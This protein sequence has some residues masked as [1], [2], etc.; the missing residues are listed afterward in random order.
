M[1]LNHAEDLYTLF[2]LFEED[3][4]I[5]GNSILT[6]DENI[7]TLQALKN[8]FSCYIDNFKTGSESFDEK[9][10]EQF[11]DADIGTR[12]VFAHAEWLWAFS[13]DDKTQWRKKEFTKRTTGITDEA[14][15][16]DVYPKGFG[17]AGQWHNQNKYWEI[18]FNLL[19]ILFLKEKIDKKE[20]ISVG[21]IS[22]WIEKICLYQKYEQV[23][24]DY[25]LPESFTNELPTQKLAACN[26]LT[27]IA[28]PE[29]YERIASDTHKWQ[30]LSSFSGLLSKE[31]IEGEKNVDEKIEI[32]RERLSNL[33]GESEFDFYEDEFK[34]VWNY[35]LAQEGFSE[36]QGLQYKKAIILFGPPGTSKTYT[37]KRLGHALIATAYLSNP[38]NVETY[39]NGKVDFTA[40]RI[41]H[42]QLHSNY[43]YEDFVAGIQL[44]NHSTKVVKGKLFEI[45]EAAEKDKSNNMP[46]VLILDE[47]NRI[48]LSRLFGEVFSALENRE[49]P[50][51][52][53]IGQ[54]SLIIPE[55]LYV[56]GTMNEIDFSLERIDFALRRRFLWFFYGF[57][58]NTL[59]EIIWNKNQK[60]NTRLK[61]E[62]VE[63]F[64]NNAKS[65]NRAVVDLPELGEQYQVGHTFFAEVVNIFHSYKELN[66]YSN[67]LKNQLFRPDGAA[68]IL[69]D[70]SIGPIIGAFLGNM[71]KQSKDD[72]IEEL[73]EVFLR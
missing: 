32:I 1:K 37:A 27:Y 28:F 60:L 53:G 4:L 16:K 55:N 46:H 47:I 21:Q 11:K 62:E 57:E 66:G 50:I 67:R 19:L 59:S 41:H 34:Q 65:L 33:S 9:V 63:R 7:L 48:D 54:L 73:K 43:N 30:I 26:I 10:A 2:N 18:K 71:D 56:I 64:V 39:F 49:E 5:K 25:P 70:V 61:P 72:K 31:E 36:V 68:N 44:D 38:K 15:L 3:F 20:I 17:S 42:L 29:K 52:L 40:G 69:W 23:F 22:N 24:S 35:S 51:E 6:H 58:A 14:R 13:V 12:L 45:C 8:C